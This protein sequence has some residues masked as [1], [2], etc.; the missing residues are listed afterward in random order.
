MIAVVDVLGVRNLVPFGP[1]VHEPADPDE[2][3]RLI[4]ASRRREEQRERQGIHGRRGP[5]AE[6]ERQD[7]DERERR[8]LAKRAHR[9]T[10]VRIH[11]R[12]QYGHRNPQ[13]SDGR[14][15]RS[16]GGS[17]LRHLGDSRNERWDEADRYW[18][19]ST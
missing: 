4:D 18:M 19:R 7:C 2:A 10:Q 17:D 11:H 6:G 16:V 13:P 5:D 15:H 9:Q 14:A 3:L 12:R 1:A 8:G